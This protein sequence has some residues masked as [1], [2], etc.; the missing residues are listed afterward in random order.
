MARMQRTNPWIDTFSRCVGEL[1][2][3]DRWTLNF[4]YKL[5]ANLTPLQR[6]GG[7]KVY[8]TSSF[9]RFE[10]PCSNSWS[11]AH[12][13][14][15]FHYRLKRHKGTVLLRPFQ[16]RCRDCWNSFERKPIINQ[17]QMQK[18]LDRLILKI[19]KNCYME[20]V[21]ELERNLQYRKTKPHET[22]LCEACEW[23]LCRI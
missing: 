8:T 18:V 23:G 20:E 3:T 13:V 9:G 2:Y 16:Q 21:P 11:S 10:C 1:Q 5:D 6:E 4:N 15:L 12:V 17:T 7:W 22:S 19:C 14:V